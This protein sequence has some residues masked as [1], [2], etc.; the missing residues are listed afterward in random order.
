MEKKIGQ[1]MQW[2]IPELVDLNQ[3]DKGFG[4]CTQG[5]GAE[6]TCIPTGGQNLGGTG[7]CT[8]GGFAATCDSGGDATINP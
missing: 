8:V 4:E 6:L 3:S 7:L 1:K 2:I 5:S